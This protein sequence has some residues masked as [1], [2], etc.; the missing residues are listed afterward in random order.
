MP[1]RPRGKASVDP[2]DPQA[3][4]ICDRCGALHNHSALQFQYQWQGNTLEN[5]GSLVCEPCLDKPSAFLRS[6]VLAADPPTVLNARP[7]NYSIDEA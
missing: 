1:Y 4:A 3:F 5:L 6:I 7:E 2:E